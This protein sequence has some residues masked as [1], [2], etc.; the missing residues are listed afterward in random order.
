[1]YN[2]R[3]SRLYNS[4][5]SG[6]VTP[7]RAPEAAP[8]DWVSFRNLFSYVRRL[9]AGLVLVQEGG[10]VPGDDSVPAKREA[11]YLVMAGYSATRFLLSV[12]SSSRWKRSSWFLQAVPG[13][14]APA[15]SSSRTLSGRIQPSGLPGSPRISLKGP[16]LQR[17]SRRLYCRMFLS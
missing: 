3:T 16:S 4:V 12:G 13:G 10:K 5:A 9:H 17:I 6:G 8:V 14:A 7:A 11:R 2:Y 1:M 15:S